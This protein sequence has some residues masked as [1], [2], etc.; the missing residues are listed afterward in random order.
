MTAYD[1]TGATPYPGK[2]IDSSTTP[3]I[4]FGYCRG[5]MISER[6]MQLYVDNVNGIKS[7]FNLRGVAEIGSASGCIKF[8]DDYGLFPPAGDMGFEAAL[9]ATLKTS[10]L[11]DSD[12]F[13]SMDKWPGYLNIHGIYDA[14]TPDGAVEAYNRVRGFKDVLMVYGNHF[15]YLYAPNFPYVANKVESFCK[16][17]TINDPSMNNQ[18]KTTLWSEITKAPPIDLGQLWTY[19]YNQEGNTPA[20]MGVLKG[21]EQKYENALKSAVDAISKGNVTLEAK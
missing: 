8:T 14:L 4:L 11:P 9:Q 19:M 3:V 7:S 2:L 18:G 17:V 1:A 10:F 6:A 5:A 20:P 13:A 12:V 15:G 21:Q 16:K